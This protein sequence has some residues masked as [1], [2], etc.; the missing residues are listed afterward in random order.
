MI[1]AGCGGLSAAFEL[2]RGGANVVLLESSEASEI[3]KVYFFIILNQQR[4]HLASR[5][6]D[7]NLQRGNICKSSSL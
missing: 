2:K 7:Q 5:W 3:I 4:R 6:A 1:G